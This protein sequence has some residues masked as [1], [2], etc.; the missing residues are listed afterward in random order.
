MTKLTGAF[1]IIREKRLK[2]EEEGE[3]KLNKDGKQIMEER[4][5]N[6]MHEETK[7]KKA[8]TRKKEA[9]YGSDSGLVRT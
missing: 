8:K 9:A 4:Q 3:V 7:E 5:K 6:V 1:R 2:N